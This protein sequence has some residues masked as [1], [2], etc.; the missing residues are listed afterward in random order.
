[1]SS[2][3]PLVAGP[4]Q[5]IT[6]I[7]DQERISITFRVLDYFLSPLKIGVGLNIFMDAG[8]PAVRELLL[9][10]H[11]ARGN[12]ESSVLKTCCE[13]L[14]HRRTWVSKFDTAGQ[15]SKTRKERRAQDAPPM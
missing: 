9:G 12:G 14:Q 11:T 8:A 15:P 5:S 13:R 3:A 4:E 6:M 7:I 1:M 10:N 2:Y